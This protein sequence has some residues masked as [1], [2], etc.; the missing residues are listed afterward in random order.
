MDTAREVSWHLFIGNL[1]KWKYKEFLLLFE[2]AN[3]QTLP[4]PS[5]KHSFCNRTWHVWITI[6]RPFPGEL[7]ASDI[8]L[9]L[10]IYL[11][12]PFLNSWLIICFSLLTLS[13]F[14][15]FL[16]SMHPHFSLQG[17]S[18]SMDIKIYNS[19]TLGEQGPLTST[20]GPPQDLPD[21]SVGKDSACNAEDISSILG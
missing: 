6:N 17:G 20:F 21:N 4:P 12:I 2:S 5:F 7:Q 3:E 13:V 10:L 16:N 15:S 9:L 1:Y 14:G 18:I 8:D 19:A 11:D